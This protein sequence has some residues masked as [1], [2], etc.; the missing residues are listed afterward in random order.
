VGAGDALVAG[1]AYY[2]QK[3][4][5]VLESYKFAHATSYAYLIH[6]NFHLLDVEKIYNEI[7]I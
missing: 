3:S 5:D 2:Y 6:P 1:F 4:K 7:Q